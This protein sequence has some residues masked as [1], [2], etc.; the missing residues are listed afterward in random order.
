MHFTKHIL[1]C[2]LLLVSNHALSDVFRIAAATNLRYVLPEI[3]AKFHETTGH[4]VTV[5]YAASGTLT[6]QIIHGAP[7]Q[8]FLSANPAYIEQLHAAK[9]IETKV[10]TFAYGQLALFSATH[11]MLDV[12][13]GIPSIKAALQQSKLKKVAIANPSHA[14][15]GQAAKEQLEKFGLWDE[16]QAHLLVAENASQATQFTLSSRSSVG[17]IPFTHAIQPQISKRGAFI[18]LDSLLPQQAA[19]ISPSSDV[20]NAFVTF[21]SSNEAADILTSQGFLLTG[22]K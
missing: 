22:D 19:V 15:Y 12:V 9:R 8:V 14:P 21:L 4:N 10:T 11:A 7:F 1:F 20:A 16:I 2:L 3:T 17:F 18:K 6:T 5:S 13:K